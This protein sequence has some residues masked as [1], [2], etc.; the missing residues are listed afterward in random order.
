MKKLL[1]L[2]SLLLLLPTFAQAYSPV[3]NCSNDGSHAL[4]YS[5]ATNAFACTSITGGGSTPGGSANDIQYNS[6]GTALGGI[7]LTN[8]QLVVGQTSSTPL[9]KTLSGDCTLAASGA[10]TCTKTNGSSFTALATTTPGTG[11]ATALGVN[12][13]SAGAFVVNGG[14]LGTPSSG[15]GTNITG[16]PLTTGVTGVLPVANGGT[17]ASSASITAFNNITG[18]TASGATGTTSTN[19]VFSASPTF[20]GTTAVSN[21]TIA[22]TAVITSSSATAFVVGPNGTTNPVFAVDASTASQAAGLKITGAATGGTP[23]ITA[24]DSGSNTNM[25]LLPKGTG[26]VGI[27]TATLSSSSSLVDIYYA[28]AD[29]AGAP[30]YVDTGSSSI[31]SSVAFQVILPAT[32]A[33]KA[34][35]FVNTT[36]GNGWAAFAFQSVTGSDTPGLCL[37][38][39]GVTARD[40]CMYR[41]AATTLKFANTSGTVIALVGGAFTGDR[42]IPA[43]STVPTN[44]LYL[45]ASNTLGWGIN[46]AAEMQLTST[47]LSPAVDDGNALGTTSLEWSDLFLASGGVINFNNGNMTITHSAAKLAVAGGSLTVSGSVGIGTATARVSLDNGANTD[48]DLVAGG[49]TAQRPGSPVAG[50]VRYNTSLAA[51]EAYIGSAWQSLLGAD[52]DNYNYLFNAIFFVDQEKE[53][54]TYSLGNS[55]AVIRTA[56]QWEG[57]ISNTNVSSVTAQVVSTNALSQEYPLA[58]KVVFGTGSSTLGSGDFS[59]LVA[60]IE[61]SKWA[62]LGYGGAA[63]RPVSISFDAYSNKSG[64]FGVALCNAD[65]SR[66]W[67]STCTTTANTHVTCTVNIT[68]GDTTGTWQSTSNTVGAYLHVTLQ[69]GT[70]VLTSST[71][72]WRAAC[73]LGATGSQTNYGSTNADFFQ[74]TKVVL[75]R[76]TTAIDIPLKT[77]KDDLEEARR[78]YQKSFPEGTAVAQ[79]AGVA[80]ST[81]MRNPIA[82][83][84]PSTYIHFRPTMAGNPTFTTYNP[85]AS[86]SSGRNVTAGSDQALTVDAPSAKS[87]TGTIVATNGTITTLGDYICFHW[88]ADKR[89]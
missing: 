36:D 9:A 44:G 49:T 43:S 21:I 65:D 81:C 54:G 89:L 42:F 58:E 22:G 56:D 28:G 79:N 19:I 74:I 57:V 8:G 32:G 77:Y 34:F 3:P 50:M 72:Q 30:L 37:G 66:G 29:G 38:P 47:A 11:V 14:A 85:S 10:I 83:G 4:T 59:I 67:T 6:G 24:T 70:G 69:G 51:L 13:G 68:T 88:T 87:T 15:V 33:R 40:S 5:T 35:N 86:N 45:P 75:N 27:G 82:I 62:T 46:S 64:T 73:A 61:G 78:Y 41:S 55:G 84:D 26:K 39:G 71:N 76:G 48:A 18:Y 80:G 17:N 63:A 53:Y 2:L 60:P 7:T 23:T 25:A 52:G 1:S 20:T 12:V 16:L 31:S